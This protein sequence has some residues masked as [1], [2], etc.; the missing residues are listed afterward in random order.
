MTEHDSP[1]PHG[2]PMAGA[3]PGIV[4]P[5][6]IERFFAEHVAGAR[7]PFRYTIIAGGHSNLTY[8]VDDTDGNRFVLRRPPLGHILASAHDMGREHRIISAV[9]RSSVPVAPALALSP[10]DAVN[11]APFYVMGFVEGAILT[12][13]ADVDAAVADLDARR[14]I[15]EHVADVLADLHR[16]DVDSIGLGEL[17][18]REGYLERQLKRWRTQWEASK[19]RDVPAMD[20]A[21]AMLSAHK[22]VQ[23]YTGI[24]HG[25]YR[26]GNFMVRP[27][28]GRVAAV[29][30]WELCTLGDVLADVG[31]LLNNWT[32]ADEPLPPGARELPPTAAGG[33]PT[34]AELLE[35]YAARSG[36][37]VSMM[38]YYQAFSHWRSAA[39]AE[40]VK[41]RY[42]EGVMVDPDF[43]VET[44]DERIEALAAHAL[45]LIR[46]LTSR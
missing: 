23:R 38:D 21:F 1:N 16:I 41:R 29:L 33:F 19:T 13:V 2:D 43:P 39:I 42:L 25:D 4:D 18:R 10:D 27:D 26:T 5:A 6:G 3:V 17:A 9:A 37:D 7:P 22:P 35:R 31:Y 28:E 11:G 44:Y 36:F 20:E 45:D 15:G 46:R 34:R 30:D 8:R 12:V 40:G 14:R 32:Q 24:V